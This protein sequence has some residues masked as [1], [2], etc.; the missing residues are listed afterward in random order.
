MNRLL[1]ILLISAITIA[2]FTMY[3]QND[4]GRISFSFAEFT[5]ETNLLVFGAAAICLLFALLVLVKS[6]HYIKA[7][8]VYLSNRRTER[9]EENHA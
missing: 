2:G 1:Y 8:F 6:L 3:K 7:F 5:F 4:L 9:L